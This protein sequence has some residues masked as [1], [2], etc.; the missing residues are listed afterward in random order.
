M[1]FDSCPDCGSDLYNNIAGRDLPEGVFHCRDCDEFVFMK[2]I[3]IDIKF[4]KD[5]DKA[6]EKIGLDFKLIV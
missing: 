5:V 1:D 2:I 4:K 3:E 6:F